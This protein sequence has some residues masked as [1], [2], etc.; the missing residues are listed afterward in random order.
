MTAAQIALIEQ[1]AHVSRLHELRRR[2][3]ALD[4]AMKRIG[5]W[6]A[7]RLRRTYADLE[8]QPRYAAAVRFFESDLYGGENFEQRDAD[9]ARV[10]PIMVRMLPEKV[11]ATMA[12]GMEMNALAQELDRA[13]LAHLAVDSGRITVADYCDAYRKMNMRAA[14]ERQIRL[15]GEVGA[16]LKRFVKMPLIHA[17]IAM[18]RKPARMAGMAVLHDFIERGF[19]AFHAMGDAREFLATIDARETALLQAIY[20]GASAPFPDPQSGEP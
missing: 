6:Q 17:A 10:I 18:M 5:N 3:A 15:I 2:D 16:A 13:L 14:R 8:R 9:F 12:Q 19:V 7:Q 4:R 11:I 20:G 1:V